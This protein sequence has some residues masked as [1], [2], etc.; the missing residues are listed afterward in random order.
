MN[1]QVPRTAN[2]F[3]MLRRGLRE[4]VLKGRMTATEF[5]V[6]TW[7]AMSAAPEDGVYHTNASII[8]SE[9][10]MSRKQAQHALY[11]L[12]SKGYIH[13]EDT[14]GIR[15]PHPIYINKYPVQLAKKGHTFYTSIWYRKQFVGEE[16]YHA[17]IKV[18]NLRLNWH[19]SGDIS[20]GISRG[21]LIQGF[22]LKSGVLLDFASDFAEFERSLDFMRFCAP[23]CQW[24]MDFDTAF[25]RAFAGTI[26]GATDRILIL[27]TNTFNKYKRQNGGGAPPPLEK[28]AY[29][30]HRDHINSQCAILEGQFEGFSFTRF[31]A[32]AMKASIPVEVFLKVLNSMV[33][34]KDKVKN[35]YSWALSVLANE[36]K[37][38]NYAEHLKEHYEFKSQEGLQSIE[39]F[40]Q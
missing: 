5:N 28:E 9:L 30:K 38:H 33:K 24:V 23:F 17:Q 34:Q 22:G 1:T 13:Y 2:N 19:I 31:T 11:G 14:R 36:F 20:G 16:L 32:S 10:R 29:R 37:E 4:H 39:A 27:D 25:K 15:G 12:R 21:I 35:P 7:M 40:L 6:F 18:R 26:G 8:S 3:V